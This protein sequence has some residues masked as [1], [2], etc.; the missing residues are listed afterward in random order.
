MIPETGVQQRMSIYSKFKG[1][2][3][4]EWPL[5]SLDIG[6]ERKRWKSLVEFQKI[7]SGI[8]SDEMAGWAGRQV[9]RVTN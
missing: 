4:K 7:L 9:V 6:T 8:I 5:R 2:A 3:E 1:P